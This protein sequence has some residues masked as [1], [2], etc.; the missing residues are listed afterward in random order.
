MTT[1]LYPEPCLS[2]SS[3]GSESEDEAS[4]TSSDGLTELIRQLLYS[5]RSYSEKMAMV[6]QEIHETTLSNIVNKGPY[7]SFEELSHD[8]RTV[9]IR[10]IA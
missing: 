10:F 4:S 7:D 2:S 1:R 6:A 5:K 8:L 3:S 9:G